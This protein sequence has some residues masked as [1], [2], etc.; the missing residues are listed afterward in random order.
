MDRE[1]S[2]FRARGINAASLLRFH[3]AR[4]L[5]WPQRLPV[6]ERELLAQ[7]LVDVAALSSLLYFTGGAVNP[8]VAC[9]LLLVLYASVALPQ[10]LG[11]GIPPALRGADRLRGS[12]AFRR[13]DSDL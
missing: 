7:I 4:G 6:T 2:S 12:G 5:F 9:Y 11:P 13:N 1:G 3:D 8:F 10:R